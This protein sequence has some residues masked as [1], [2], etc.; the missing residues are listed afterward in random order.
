MPEPII[1]SITEENAKAPKSASTNITSMICGCCFCSIT[2]F[3]VKVYD[4]ESGW[5]RNL[6]AGHFKTCSVGY[7]IIGIKVPAVICVL[8]H[9]RFVIV[10]K[11]VVILE[12]INVG[13]V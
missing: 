3:P 2:L 4:P 5:L 12:I 6:V 10:G 8:D 7:N 11:S 1:M 13:R 9:K